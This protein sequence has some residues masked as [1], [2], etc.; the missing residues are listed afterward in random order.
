MTRVFASITSVIAI[1]AASAAHAAD[2]TGFY[3]GV[4]AINTTSEV[5]YCLSCEF[6]FG[7]EPTVEIPGPIIPRPPIFI[8]DWANPEARQATPSG[9]GFGVYAGYNYQLPSGIVLG[10]EGAYAAPNANYAEDDV[11]DAFAIDTGYNI[12]ITSLSSLRARAGY[13]SGNIMFYATA[14]IAWADLLMDN[15]DDPY[16]SGPGTTTF[17]ESAHE[18]T[19]IGLGLEYAL[20][21]NMKVRAQYL[22][23]DF[24][25]DVTT[26]MP[27]YYYDN[28]ASLS[29]NTLSVGFSYNF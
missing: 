24:S 2:W 29:A 10:V 1:T 15:P 12:G 23:Y 22:M 13:A 4:E 9:L 26:E 20:N 25:D 11:Y 6:D 8:S 21:D 28:A 16:A 19:V 3:A 27:S 7:P 17:L 5:N 18:G 14:G